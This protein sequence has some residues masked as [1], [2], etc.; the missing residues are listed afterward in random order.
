MPPVPLS[1]TKTWLCQFSLGLRM[2]LPGF[3][4]KA[5]STSASVTRTARPVSG[6]FLSKVVAG[7]GFP[8]PGIVVPS[9]SGVATVGGGPGGVGA[10]PGSVWPSAAGDRSVVAGSALHGGDERGGRAG[11]SH[12]RRMPRHALERAVL[13][14]PAAPPCVRAIGPV[15]GIVDEARHGSIPDRA[16]EVEEVGELGR[17]GTARDPTGV[18]QPRRHVPLAATR[19]ESRRTGGD[20]RLLAHRR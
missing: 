1:S 2:T 19:F 16:L 7:G 12:D 9:A 4:L 13:R 6:A 3:C 17:V 18:R 15:A 14:R 5:C 10:G 11:P 20:R 8:M